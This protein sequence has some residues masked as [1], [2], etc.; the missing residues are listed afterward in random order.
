MRETKGLFCGQNNLYNHVN[1]H[2]YEH[3]YNHVYEHVYNHV[4]EHVYVYGC[5]QALRACARFRCRRHRDSD[6]RQGLR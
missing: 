6:A 4:Y 3:V 2:V 1:I 5:N